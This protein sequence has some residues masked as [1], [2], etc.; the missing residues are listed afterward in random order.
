MTR[1][2]RD[3]LV[4][5]AKSQ[6][7]E[8][9]YQELIR[10][11]E[12]G[13]DVAI[14]DIRERDEFAQ[15]HLPGAVFIPRGFLELQIEQVEFDRSK[16]VVLYCAGG[17]RSALAARNLK[18]MGYEDVQSLIGGFNG[19]KDAGLPFQIPQLL[20]D[21][22]KIRYSRHILLNEVGEEGQLKLLT[23]KVLLIGAGG[24][25]SPAAMYLAAA[26]VGTLGIVDF[27]A[28]DTSNLQRQLLHGTKDVGRPKV[29]SAADRLHDINPEVEVV[30]YPVPLSSANA[31]EIIKDYD[32]V[33]NGSDNF[34]T[35]YLVNDACQFLR[36]PLVDGSIFMFE[37]QVTVY[38][39]AVPE[40]GMEGGPCYR[41]L[42]PDP[43]PPGE[44][45]SCAEAGVLGV[46]PGIVGSLQA[47]EAIKLILGAGE[48]LIGRLLM[49]DTLDMEFRTLNVP[50][51]PDCPVCGENPT[52]TELIDYEQFCG[53]PS[54]VGN[55]GFHAEGVARVAEAS[56]N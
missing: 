9:T 55:N 56:V 5:L 10:R 11:L 46:L 39:P 37:G 54:S 32:I 24:L 47:L 16:P 44:I 12:D 6:I 21:E 19:W 50:R 42:Y 18:E 33:I 31:L 4:A 53:L 48:P 34:P 51:D 40:R 2:N 8:V 29:D 14:V 28:V 15:G 3:Q 20:N 17:V 45:P 13:D 26:G 7:T 43:P 52:V 22:Q 23:S 30:S 25:G 38:H 35:R 49:V 27:D 41:C 36:K 1:L